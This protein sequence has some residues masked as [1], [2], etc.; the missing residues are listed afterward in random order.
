M[1][2]A[3][4]KALMKQVFIFVDGDRLLSAAIILPW[5]SPTFLRLAYFSPSPFG[6]IP[7]NTFTT[8]RKKISVDTRVCLVYNSPSSK[9][10]SYLTQQ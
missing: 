7:L 5:T 1:A 9:N 2:S 3:R 6:L 4:R 10:N 8:G